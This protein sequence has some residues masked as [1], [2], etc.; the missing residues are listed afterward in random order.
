MVKQ[1]EGLHAEFSIHALG[2]LGVLD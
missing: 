1:I 2:D